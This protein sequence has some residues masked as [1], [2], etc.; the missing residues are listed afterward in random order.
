MFARVRPLSRGKDF[1]QAGRDRWE[2]MEGNHFFCRILISPYNRRITVSEFNLTGVEG[3]DEMVRVLE[4]KAASNGLDKIWLKSGEKWGAALLD[5]GMRTEA[6]IPGYYG[7]L[8]PALIASRYLSSSRQTPSGAP[9]ETA[10]FVSGMKNRPGKRVLPAGVRLEWGRPE[11]CTALAWLYESVFQTYPF[12]VFDPGYLAF[13]MSHDVYY[14]SA[15]YEGEPVAVAAA[16][17]NWRDQNAEMTDFATLPQWR[18]HGLACCILEQLEIQLKSEGI[19][20]LYTIARSSS[21]GMN[22]VFAN[23]GYAYRGVLLNNCNIAGAFEDMNVW[24]K[25]VAK[26]GSKYNP[27]D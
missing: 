18:G 21:K 16:E 19:R 6:K 22:Q 23:A 12:P 5:A 8:R 1:V 24:S 7:G 26:T 11:Q 25:V 9:G 2:D 15:W 3:A 10:R 4:G 20:C 13:T 27:T 14:L 17:I